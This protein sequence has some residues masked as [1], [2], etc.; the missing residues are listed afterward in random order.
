MTVYL[1]GAGPGDPGLITRRGAELLE[2]ADVVVFDRLVDRR[3][4]DLAPPGALRVDVG[5]RAGEASPHRQADINRLL[6][7][8]GRGAATVVRLKGGDPFVF[9][10]G[11][12]EA[13]ALVA[14]GVAFEVVPGVTSAFAAPA[15][16]GVPVT[17][18][19]VA[20]AVTVVSGHGG[21]PGEPGAVDWES[22]AR[23]GGTLV[24]LMGTAG[25]AEI[26]RR[27]VA[28]GR[29]PDTPVVVVHGATTASQARVRTTL[30]GLAGVELGPPC[31]IVVGPVAA[32]EL[33][34]PGDGA[35][36]GLTVVVTRPAERSG[37]LVDALAEA[38][39]RVVELPVI[40]VVD[41]PDGGAALAAAAA[42]AARFDWVVFTSAQ[43]VARFVAHLRDGRDLGSARL[44]A[45]GAATARALADCLLVADLVP[46]QASAQ[47][48]VDA[49]PGAPSPGASV[50]FPRARAARDVV[51]PGLRAKG[52]DVTEVDAYMTVAADPAG[53]AGGSDEVLDAAAAADV[54]VFTSPSTVEHY[55]ALA[56]G[57]PVPPT[58]VC[59]GPVTAEA[60]ARAGYAVD[61][62]APEPSA[63]A[64]VAGLAAH[65][66]ARRAA[67]AGAGPA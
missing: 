6:V 32:L 61:V 37:A 2:R 16:A 38:G 54:V 57:R 36:R 45:V 14:A 65:V 35:L 28:G 5:T 26:A 8:H 29:P 3:L 39:A 7:E 66:G 24:V 13:Q 30:A 4:L 64:L 56:A 10:R 9:G 63:P 40:A 48:L 50:L 67:D 33:V 25:R 51:G 55:T 42:G 17:Q 43:A 58:V 59:I 18:R 15:A 22:L 46:D 47:G 60:A 27:L 62:V 41:P 44:A 23:A 20:S 1:V 11:G 53:G 19:G 31:V 21:A 12:E 34:S 52:W 49:M